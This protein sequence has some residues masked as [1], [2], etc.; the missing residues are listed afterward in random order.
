MSRR[1]GHGHDHAD[2]RIN[3]ALERCLE[4]SQQGRHRKVLAEVEGLL[5]G[6][7]DDD[8]AT[9]QLLIWKAQALLSMGCPERALPSASSSWDLESSPH[10]CHL[11]SSALNAVGDSQQSEE[12]LRMGW[13][14]FPD[15]I[16]LPMQL[17][18]ILAE[19]GR[20]PEALDV[21]DEVTPT[22]QLPEDMQVFLVGL[23]ANLLANVGRWSEAEEVLR[24]GIG[25]HP[26][27]SLL[28]ETRETLDRERGRRDAELDLVE[29]W[30][31]TLKPL[32][33][34][35]AE[36]DEAI[37]RCGS[38]LELP[39]LVEMSA[40]R[41]W[42]AYLQSVTVR[43]QSPNAWGAAVMAAVMELD[44]Q[45]T[46][47]ASV[48]RCMGVRPS[49]V[50]SVVRRFRNYLDEQDVEFARRAFAAYTNPRLSGLPAQH[51]QGDTDGARIVPFPSV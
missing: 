1:T 24:E 50:R 40:R 30:R 26:E 5:E 18:M 16:H 42:R 49:T 8:H 44:G 23:R 43:L 32:D 45:R 27:S 13:E 4:W 2:A 37:G 34:V 46:S 31:S 51:G 7:S 20:L 12:L 38:I 29:S 17:A 36:V 11:M 19:Q 9:A 47:A 14:V 33:G 3:R 10:A 35:A 28:H 48:A 41:L 21:L 39:E 15:A 25:R 22:T 6:T